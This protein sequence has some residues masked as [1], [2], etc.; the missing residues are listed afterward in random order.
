MCPKK[1]NR[2][3]IN[4][5]ILLGLGLIVL[6]GVIAFHLGERW[7]ENEMRKS[8]RSANIQGLSENEKYIALRLRSPQEFKPDTFRALRGIYLPYA[9]FPES[10]QYPIETETW[11]CRVGDE[12]LHFIGGTS[13]IHIDEKILTIIGELKRIPSLHPHPQA[14]RFEKDKGWKIEDAIEWLD[15]RFKL[16]RKG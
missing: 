16:E 11:G 14:L 2:C 4:A 13:C 1:D 6:I 8:H 10:M 5:L 3:Q 9:H 12:R 15:K 7:M